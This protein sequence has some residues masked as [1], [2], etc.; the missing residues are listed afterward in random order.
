[1]WSGHRSS[2]DTVRLLAVNPS[3]DDIL[4]WSKDIDNGAKV[5][6]L[7]HFVAN[8][9][10]ADRDGFLNASG[11]RVSSILAFV[12]GS[13]CERDTGTDSSG[14]SIVQWLRGAST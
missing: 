10:C 11:T 12:T 1:M 3:T 5:G 8:V 2:R 6:E 14:N 4:A 13:D 9:H 7:A